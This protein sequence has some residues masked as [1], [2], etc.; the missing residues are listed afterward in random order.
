VVVYEEYGMI[1]ARLYEVIGKKYNYL[2]GYRYGQANQP[3]QGKN[4]ELEKI[5]AS[6][7]F[8]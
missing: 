7:K 2:F 1:T 3:S 8:F 6:A 4:K 5:I